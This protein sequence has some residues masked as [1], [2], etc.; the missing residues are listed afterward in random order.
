MNIKIILEKAVLKGIKSIYEV[1]LQSVEF[2]AT[3]KDFEGDITIVVFSLLRYIKGNPVEIG[4]KIGTYLKANV[5]EV[6]N[7]SVVKGFLN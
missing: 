2:Q 7:F 4:T 5:K 6:S 3:R 1:D